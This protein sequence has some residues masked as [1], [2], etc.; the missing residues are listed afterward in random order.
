[1]QILHSQIVGE[2]K[3]LLILH[4]FLGM[5][6]N[7]RT[8]ALRFAEK[9]FQVHT[10][11][12]RNHGH[13][14]H[15][16]EFSYEIMATDLLRYMDFHNI[17]KASIIGH[18]MGGKTTMLFAVKNPSRAEKIVIVDISPKNYPVHHQVIIDSLSSVDFSQQKTRGEVDK[19]ISKFI[20]DA[21][22]RQF[23]L[24]NLYWVKEG[25]L[26]FRMN[27][28]VLRNNLV[29]IGKALP[30]GTIFNGETLFLSGEKSSYIK[31]EDK[32]LIFKHFPNSIIEKVHSGHWIQAENPTEFFEKTIHFLT[33][34]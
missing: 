19:Q 28:P 32:E 7:W 22:V 24:K 15:S 29:E 20:L 6:D 25:Q 13:S 9:G 21:G 33:K 2:G 31:E 26:G 5:A 10:I 3:P 16:D 18:S 11:D 27:L 30:E 1:M 23:L 14:F 8:M 17:E 4:G 12:A 34:K